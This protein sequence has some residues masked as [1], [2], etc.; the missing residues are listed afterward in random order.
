[1]RST[2]ASRRTKFHGSKWEFPGLDINIGEE[3]QEQEDTARTLIFLTA[4]ALTLI[5]ALIAVPFQSYLK[6]LIFLLGAPTRLE[7]RGVGALAPGH[8]L[9]DGVAGRHDCR[10]R[11]SGQ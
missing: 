4:I 3:R 6:P 10:Q 11:R 9:V 7:R 8:A 2:P 5:Y 1:M